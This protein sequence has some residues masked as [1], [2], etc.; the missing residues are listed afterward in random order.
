MLPKREVFRY[1][2]LSVKGDLSGFSADGDIPFSLS[3]APRTSARKNTGPYLLPEVGTLSQVASLT[4]RNGP[5]AQ[6]ISL[7][8]LDRFPNLTSL[9]LWGSFCDLEQMAGLTQLNRLELRFMPNLDDLAP[10]AAEFGRPFSSW[11]AHAAKLAN[12]AY[13]TA[14]AALTNART[15]DDAEASLHRVL[16]A[17][18]LAEGYRDYVARRPWRSGTAVEPIRAYGAV[19]YH[20]GNGS[21]LVRHSSGLLRTSNQSSAAVLR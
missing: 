15:V 6:P 13:N 12:R 21:P 20:G 14:Q 2:R 4:L 18:Q 7:H 17:F 16:P 11:D 3:S 10:L 19:A 5:L 8:C 9:N 1:F